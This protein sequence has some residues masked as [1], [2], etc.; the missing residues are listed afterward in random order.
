M[1]FPSC[2]VSKYALKPWVIYQYRKLL[3]GGFCLLK[4]RGLPP[5]N[6]S[7]CHSG[8]SR[9]VLFSAS[10][11]GVW[12]HYPGAFVHCCVYVTDA[13]WSCTAEWFPCAGITQPVITTS[14]ANIRLLL[15]NVSVHMGGGWADSASHAYIE[16]NDSAKSIEKLSY[17][18]LPYLLSDTTRDY[19]LLLKYDGALLTCFTV[20]LR[21]K[22]VG[23]P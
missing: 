1:Q 4:R 2:F 16:Y 8:A 6:S 5:W 20:E 22:A 10:R 13:Q 7:V 3:C 11:N 12:M 23:R 14:S 17:I 9:L 18:F 21:T 19:E 15:G